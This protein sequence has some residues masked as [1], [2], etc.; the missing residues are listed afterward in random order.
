MTNDL[1]QVKIENKKIVIE[2]VCEGETDNILREGRHLTIVE[3]LWLMYSRNRKIVYNN[4]VLDVEDLLKIAKNDF[5][6]ITFTVYNDLRNRGK[7]VDVVGDNLL[8][9]HIGNRDIDVYILEENN[10]VLLSRLIELIELS[11]RRGRD[12]IFALVDKHGDVTYYSTSPM[13][14]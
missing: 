10:L 8:L 1:I 3:A 9:M 5:V 12:V 2:K 4:R 11:H 7:K 6:W 14:L 13:T